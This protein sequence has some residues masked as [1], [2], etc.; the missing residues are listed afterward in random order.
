MKTETYKEIAG[1]GKT[2]QNLKEF[3]EK[4]NAMNAQLTEKLELMTRQLGEALDRIAAL[5]AEQAKNQRRF[6]RCAEE[7]NELKKE[8][9]RLRLT[10][11]LNT[12]SIDRLAK[13][14]AEE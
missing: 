14:K 6:V 1:F 3:G 13:A 4:Q 5:E 10:S 8:V 2:G 11:K 12:S 9:D 7:I